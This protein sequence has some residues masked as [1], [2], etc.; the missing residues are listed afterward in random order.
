MKIVVLSHGMRE[1]EFVDL[2]YTVLRGPEALSDPRLPQALLAI[3][4]FR[5][6]AKKVSSSYQFNNSLRKAGIPHVVLNREGPSHFGEKQWR[7]FLMRHFKFMDAYATHTLQNCRGFATDVIYLP[8]AARDEYCCHDPARI[9]QL[10]DPANYRHDVSFF[11]N[12]HS[13]EMLPRAEFLTELTQRLEKLG[14][15]L[16]IKGGKLSLEEQIELI[17]SSRINLNYHAGTDSRYNSRQR[18]RPRCWGMSERC[19]GIP[20]AGGFLLSDERFHAADD[21]IPGIEWA[22]FTDVQDCVNRIR[23][24][25]DHFQEARDIAEA[26]NRRVL[27]QHT[28]M[29]RA[30]RLIAFATQWHRDKKQSSVL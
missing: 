18:Y 10:R 7:L 12:I 14:I 11:G 26:A 3:S 30:L 28:Y 27:T 25:L 16:T 17:Q 5:S 2:G 21:F 29:Q 23:Y 24:Y 20:A 6:V 19:Y 22:D 15:S 8:S 13:P 9:K 1:K 4:S